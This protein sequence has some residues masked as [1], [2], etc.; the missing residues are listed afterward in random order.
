MQGMG[1]RKIKSW[2]DARE[3]NFLAMGYPRIEPFTTIAIPQSPYMCRW[4]FSQLVIECENHPTL[5]HWSFTYMLN[6]ALL[7][8]NC[9]FILSFGRREKNKNTEVFACAPL[10]FEL[11]V[12]E[13]FKK[14]TTFK[15]LAGGFK[16]KNTHIFKEKKRQPFC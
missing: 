6:Q 13:P 14:M 7:E 12:I 9:L 10:S 2:A 5:F 8:R 16:K 15:L 11:F 1:L 4:Y 3:R